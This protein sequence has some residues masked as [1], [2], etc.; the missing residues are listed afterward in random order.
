M[1]DY[2]KPK[3]YIPELENLSYTITFHRDIER[4]MIKSIENKLKLKR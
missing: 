3:K 2:N 4:A 1:T